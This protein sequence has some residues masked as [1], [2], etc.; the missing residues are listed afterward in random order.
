MIYEGKQVPK[1]SLAFDVWKLQL[2][3]DCELQGKV[4]AFDAMGD[5]V[6]E[7]LWARGLD[8]SVKAIIGQSAEYKIGPK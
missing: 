5:Y 6:L 1:K 3:K 8:P 7:L 4:S 2:R